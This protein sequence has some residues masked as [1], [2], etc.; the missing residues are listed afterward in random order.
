MLGVEA[1]FYR[2][3]TM[4]KNDIVKTIHA[5]GERLKRIYIYISIVPLV[6]VTT[7][8]QVG[9]IKVLCMVTSY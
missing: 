4:T 7:R 8:L 9:Y 6:Y 2:R 5:G 1:E 3:P